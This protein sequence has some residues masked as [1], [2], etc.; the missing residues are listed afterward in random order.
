M[1]DPFAGDDGDFPL[2][3][4]LKQSMELLLHTTYIDEDT[5]YYQDKM[6]LPESTLVSDAMRMINLDHQ[7]H[8]GRRRP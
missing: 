8:N 1:A 2:A 5:E 6:Q 3:T 4:W 7:M